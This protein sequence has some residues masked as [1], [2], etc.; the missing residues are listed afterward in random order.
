MLWMVSLTWPWPQRW[1]QRTEWF[2]IFNLDFFTLLT[3]HTRKPSNVASTWGTMDNYFVYA[4]CFGCV[5][6]MCIFSWYIYRRCYLR[7]TDQYLVRKSYLRLITSLS[8][9]FM[10]M[11][12]IIAVGRLWNCNTTGNLTVDP[13]TTCWSF[14]HTVQFF[15]ITT[16]AG[17]LFAIGFPMIQLFYIR[18]YLIYHKQGKSL[19][20][21][22]SST[23][24]IFRST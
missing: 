15:T 13:T 12:I 19:S 8:L 23:Q 11:P 2:S 21:F 9:Q 17:G 1:L 5:P 22:K 16:G 4:A 18:R 14:T 6:Y 10:Y 20:C 24:D 7:K 3:T